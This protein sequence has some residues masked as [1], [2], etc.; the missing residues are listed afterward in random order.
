MGSEWQ[1]EVGEEKSWIFSFEVW[2]I[3]L[4]EVII[5]GELSELHMRVVCV[6]CFCRDMAAAREESFSFHFLG[7]KFANLGWKN[8]VFRFVWVCMQRLRVNSIPK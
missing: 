1:F 3:L 7:T 4:L 6:V 2:E 5:A 8:C